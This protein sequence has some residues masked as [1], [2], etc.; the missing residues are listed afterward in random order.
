MPS[1]RAMPAGSMFGAF[2]A[3]DLMMVSTLSRS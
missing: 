1:R 2:S 3:G